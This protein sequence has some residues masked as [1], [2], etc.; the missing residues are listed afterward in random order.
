[1]SSVNYSRMLMIIGITIA[2]VLGSI[3]LALGFPWL[4]QVLAEGGTLPVKW[5]QLCKAIWV[6][7]GIHLFFFAAVMLY[8]V[9]KRPVLPPTILVLCGVTSMLDGVILG[10]YAPLMNLGFGT[11][12]LFMIL[13]ILLAT[14]QNFKQESNRV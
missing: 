5:Q 4:S 12:G 6:I 13:G 10:S 8:A 14:C 3:H 9:L 11:P 1:M 2:I 7:F